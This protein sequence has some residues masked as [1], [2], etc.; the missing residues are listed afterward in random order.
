MHI[1][2]LGNVVVKILPLLEEEWSLASKIVK[3][4]SDKEVISSLVEE[5]VPVA[6]VSVGIEAMEN[7]TLAELDVEIAK[8]QVEIEVLTAKLG[9]LEMRRTRLAATTL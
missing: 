4:K 3:E 1:K 5:P 8:L 6:G 2:E 9:A 7:P